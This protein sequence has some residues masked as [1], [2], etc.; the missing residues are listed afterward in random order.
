MRWPLF[1]DKGWRTDP[2]LVESSALMS[3]PVE[4]ID[5]RYACVFDQPNRSKTKTVTWR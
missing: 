3:D 2:I 4:I 5:G 1:A